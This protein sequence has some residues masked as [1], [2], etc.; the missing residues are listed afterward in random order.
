MHTQ[1]TDLSARLLATENLTVVRSAVGTASFDIQSRVLTLPMWKDMTPEIEDMLVGHEVGHALY[2]GDKYT[3]PIQENPK[4]KSYMNILEDVRIEKLIKRKYPGLR[5]RMNEGYKQLNDRD[6]FGVQKLPLDTLNL[7]DRINLYFKAG[8]QCG[9]KF[10]ADEK[11]FVNRAERIESIDEV[12][13]LADEIYKFSKEKAEEEQKKR[14]TK[15]Q[16]QDEEQEPEDQ[17]E[18]LGDD[19][20]DIPDDSFNDEETENTDKGTSKD[21]AG[22]TPEQKDQQEVEEELESSTE[23]AFSEKLEEL[24]DQDTI[25]KYHAIHPCPYDVVVG[26]KQILQDLTFDFGHIIEGSYYYNRMYGTAKVSDFE[27]K[28]AEDYVKFK[29][30]SQSSVNYLIKEFEMKKSAQLYK[31][32]QISKIGTLDMRKVYAYQ[33]QDDLFKRVTT[34]PSGKNHGMIMLIDWSGSMGDVI[35]DTIKQVINLA[36]FCNKAQIPYRVFAFTSQYDGDRDRHKQR[37]QRGQYIEQ[38]REQY[39]TTGQSVIDP[40][41]FSLLELFS[42]KMTMS[43]FNN[44]SKKLLDPRVFWHAGYDLGGTPLNEALLWVYT[45][46][47]EYTRNNRIEKMNLI[48]LSDGAGGPLNASGGISRYAYGRYK[49]QHLVRDPVTKKTYPFGHDANLQAETLLKMIKDRYNVRIVGFYICANRRRHLECAIKDNVHAWKGNSLALVETM[50]DDFKKQGFYSLKGTGRDD[51]FIV[52]M[53]STKIADEELTVTSDMSSR[54][55]ASTLG[56]YLNTKKT[57]RILL[58]RFIEYIA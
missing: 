58:S 47:G 56:K 29:N 48:T 24:A 11:E 3:K 6:F 17:E 21:A 51:L 12:I 31:R 2:T 36:M 9:V 8:F 16:P 38:L 20:D 43:E 49:E 30:D 28:I 39:K 25:Y 7:I 19:P 50:R 46:I 52:P 33:L 35:A 32:A 13:E 53:E 4:M 18:D 34:L 54:K 40:G 27:K 41:G 5:K 23:R 57:S 26:Y 22:K 55:L 45:N 37:H 14:K 42:N 15:S 44:M 10:S 1:A